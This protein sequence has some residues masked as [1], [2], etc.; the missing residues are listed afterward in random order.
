[1]TAFRG[2]DIV[3]RLGGDEFVVLAIGVDA[4]AALDLRARTL[5]EVDAFNALASRPYRLSVSIGAALYDPAGPRS[6][7]ALVSAADTA[8]Y[9]HKKAP[10]AA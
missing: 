5:R 1:M 4:N 8:M 6:L 10:R 2:S 7:E 9:E 3:A